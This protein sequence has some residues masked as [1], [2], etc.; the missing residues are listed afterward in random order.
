MQ[1]LARISRPC[2]TPFI[3]SRYITSKTYRDVQLRSFTFTACSNLEEKHHYDYSS[4]NSRPA[5]ELNQNVTKEEQDDY[6]KRL[7][8]ELKDKQMRS[9]WTREGSDKPP[10]AQQREAGAMT[11]GIAFSMATWDKIAC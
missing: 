8:K 10:V 11:K 5:N 7:S 4:P 3:A 9:P 6:N 1:G 2:P